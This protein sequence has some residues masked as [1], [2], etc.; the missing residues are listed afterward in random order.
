MANNI[1]KLN[2][3]LKNVSFQFDEINN[4]INA[5]SKELHKSKTKDGVL[6]NNKNKSEIQS[7]TEGYDVLFEKEI[8]PLDKYNSDKIRIYYDGHKRKSRTPLH[9]HAPFVDWN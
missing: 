9:Q 5:L 7:K 2:N 1:P 3:N 8:K 6:K 4:T